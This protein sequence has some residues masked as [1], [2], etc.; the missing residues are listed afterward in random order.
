MGQAA[1]DLRNMVMH[2]Q[3]MINKSDLSK[4][5]YLYNF[6]SFEEFFLQVQS[7][8][9]DKRKVANK[10]ALLELMEK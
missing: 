4:N 9:E 7:L 10:I 3:E 8:L 6:K 1:N 2:S 5:D